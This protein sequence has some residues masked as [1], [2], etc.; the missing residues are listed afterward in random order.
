[1]IGTG[2]T[3][4]SELTNNGLAP[5]LTTRQLLRFVPEVENLCKVDCVQPINIDSTNMTPE[6]WLIIAG[7]I[8]EAYE[9]YDG[10]VV[11]HGTDTM[12]YTAAALSYLVQHSP[13]PIVLTG[14]QKPMG[15][16]GSD[17]E[18][19]LENAF[20]YAVDDES[21]GV[22]IVFNGSVILGTR[23]RKVR[24]KSYSA[25]SSI[26]FPE[27]A[28]IQD[29]K[30]LRYIE[31]KVTRAVH[32]YDRLNKNVGLVKLIPGMSADFLGY[33]M[34]NTDAVIVESFGVGGIPSL[35][36][37]RFYDC[38]AQGLKRGKIVVMTTQVQNE[39]SN[40]SVYS[41]GH[42]LK[43]DFNILEAYDM[44]TESVVAKLMWIL[45]LTNDPDEVRRLF[46]TRV[47]KD[48]LYSQV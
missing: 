11:S 48:L 24:S 34:D 37:S 3:I 30:I 45:G 2:G 18:S 17:S 20:R 5:A 8:H 43:T 47:A 9:R 33:V 19:N 38:I 15:I 22:Q 23:A 41:V 32:F 35:M 44:T 29:G 21:S 4:A 42:A 16:E 25:F 28:M 6:D 7:V 39:G 14:A 1:M 36:G 46:Y 31:T 13:K 27:L 12:A 10:F 26:N 40:L